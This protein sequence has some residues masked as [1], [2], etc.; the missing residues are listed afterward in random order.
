MGAV[1]VGLTQQYMQKKLDQTEKQTRGIVLEVKEEFGL[2]MTANIILI[3]G[4]LKKSYS[5]LVAKR[6]TVIVKKPKSILLPKTL[7]DMRYPS[8]KFRPVNEVVS[9]S[10]IKIASPDLEGVLPGRP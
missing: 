1:L 2:A 3:D 4:T 7:Y 5:I 6:D 9:A 10:Y 8:Y